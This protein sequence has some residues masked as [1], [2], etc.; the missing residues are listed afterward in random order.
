MRDCER[1]VRC[2]FIKLLWITT[3]M[4]L[5]VSL[6]LLREV[7]GREPEIK[8]SAAEVQRT[9]E[10]DDAA[11][12]IAVYLNAADVDVQHTPLLYTDADAEALARMAWGES[13]GVEPL[14]VY[15]GTVSRKCQQAAAMW[16]ALNRFD[17]GFADSIIGVVSAPKQ[18]HGYAADHPLEDELLALAHDVLERWE[19][20]K[21]YGGDVGRVLPAEYLYF[22]GDGDNNH[23]AAEYRSRRYYAWTLPDV[24]EEVR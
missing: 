22:V 6:L 23:F 4:L 20:E 24:Y 17:A 10:T 14:T 19:Y 13:R 16:C 9:E 18:F 1:C 8:E 7:R 2:V 12:T 15:G 21:L 3:I 11:E 5:I